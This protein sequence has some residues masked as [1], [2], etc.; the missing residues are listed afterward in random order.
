MARMTREE[1]VRRFFQSNHRPSW[2]AYDDEDIKDCCTGLAG[3]CVY[4][5]LPSLSAPEIGVGIPLVFTNVGN[6]WLRFIIEPVMEFY[7]EKGQQHVML[8]ALAYTGE[9]MIVDTTEME[10]LNWQA[11]VEELKYQQDIL[12]CLSL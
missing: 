6:D 12:D 3:A 5:N 1:G 2:R 4:L 7:T 8:T 10:G 11:L 9:M